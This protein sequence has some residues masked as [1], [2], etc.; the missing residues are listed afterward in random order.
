MEEDYYRI[1]GVPR[2]AT[3]REIKKAYRKLARLYHPDRNPQPI[4]KTK[5]R[6]INAA[7]EVLGEP[8]KRKEYDT[9]FK[10]AK[11]TRKGV[12]V[13]AYD[14][15]F[16]I[17]STRE[18]FEPERGS[19]IV[20]DLELDLEE[21]SKGGYKEIRV[22]RQMNCNTCGG[23]GAAPGTKPRTC[24]KCGGE[25][26]ISLG[27]EPVWEDHEDLSQGD[28]RACPNC[29]GIGRVIDHKCS[30][31]EGAG[32]D[33]ITQ[34]FKVDIPR[35]VVGDEIITLKGKGNEGF[36]GGEPGDLLVSVTEKE[37]PRY[38]R[39]G[40]NLVFKRKISFPQAAMGTTVRIPLLDGDVDLYI[41]PGTQTG[42][43]FGIPNGGLPLP[44]G[45]GV[46]EMKVVVKVIT[47]RNITPRQRAL[48]KEFSNEAGEPEEPRG[49]PFGSRSRR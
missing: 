46:G 5:F 4:A 35:G 16:D 48:L 36:K 26:E 33:W 25:G 11:R 37:H 47:P 2:D 27:S 39:N 42:D 17:F 10:R 44:D 22:D 23:S 30:S 29:N 9:F 12:T 41:P 31:C 34:T 18:T 13:K 24:M 40:S 14:D 20:V 6:K 8:E 43:V 21:I 45:K 38:M 15:L 7:Y 3:Q 28:L 49:F 19:D 32:K 1:L